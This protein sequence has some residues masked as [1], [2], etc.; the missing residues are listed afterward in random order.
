MKRQGLLLSAA[1]CVLFALASP[2]FANNPGSCSQLGWIYL[3]PRTLYDFTANGYPSS[4]TCWSETNVHYVNGSTA[5]ACSFYRARFVFDSG[6]SSLWQE[7][8]VPSTIHTTTPTLDFQMDAY[9]PTNNGQANAVII[10]VI[11]E[12]NSN[13]WLGGSF[14]TQSLGTYSCQRL[15]IPLTS[16]VDLAGHTL[17]L[18]FTARSDG[19]LQANVKYISLYA[20]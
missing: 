15:T 14:W 11:D 4:D 2:A 19:N 20:E 7:M 5:D 18:S 1:V 6:N 10:D 3:A 13:T 16:S 9:D 12:T 8:P 17:K